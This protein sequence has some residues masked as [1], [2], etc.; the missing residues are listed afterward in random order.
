MQSTAA[1]GNS[2]RQGTSRL[3]CEYGQITSCQ[4]VIVTGYIRVLQRQHPVLTQGGSGSSDVDISMELVTACTSGF[5]HNV[6]FTSAAA[7]ILWVSSL[8]YGVI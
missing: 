5:N 1:C 8:M 6:R 3:R 7:C 4:S 2:T